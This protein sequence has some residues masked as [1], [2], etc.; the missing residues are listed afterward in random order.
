MEVYQFTDTKVDRP[1][2][3]YQFCL[4]GDDLYVSWYEFRFTKIGDL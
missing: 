2:I 3:H 1:R 4:M